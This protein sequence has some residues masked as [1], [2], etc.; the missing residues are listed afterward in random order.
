MEEIFSTTRTTEN[1]VCGKRKLKTLNL[2]EPVE[3]SRTAAARKREYS[4]TQKLRWL[5]EICFKQKN[6]FMMQ[7][8]PKILFSFLLV[9][10]NLLLG[11]TI[12]AK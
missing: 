10:Y 5:D 9:M 6:N 1:M 8:L 7:N 3:W 12:P 4:F 11:N 2:R